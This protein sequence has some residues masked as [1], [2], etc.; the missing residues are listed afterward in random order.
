MEEHTEMSLGKLQVVHQWY[1]ELRMCADF[2]MPSWD[3]I[4]RFKAVHVTQ[5]VNDVIL[6]PIEK[7]HHA[8]VYK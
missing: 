7:P 6:W 5:W 8:E 4:V 1:N 3:I 2:Q